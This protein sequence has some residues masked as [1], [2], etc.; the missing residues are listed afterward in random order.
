MRSTP[1]FEAIYTWVRILDE[2]AENAK[3]FRSPVDAIMSMSGDGEAFFLR[4]MLPT[5]WHLFM[6]DGYERSI[7]EAARSVQTLAF[8]I[9]WDELAKPSNNPFLL[10]QF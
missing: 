10:N 9:D 4:R 3:V 1:D 8:T 5:F 6:Y 2:L 7:R